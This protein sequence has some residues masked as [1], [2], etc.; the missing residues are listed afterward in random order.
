MRAS[1]QGGNPSTR[2]AR[3]LRG[4]IVLSHPVRVRPKVRWLLPSGGQVSE[5]GLYALGILSLD[6]K[7]D[8]FAAMLKRRPVAGRA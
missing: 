8:A 3:F 2:Y 1:G 4:T 7:L 5:K 6:A